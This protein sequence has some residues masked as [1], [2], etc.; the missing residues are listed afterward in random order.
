MYVFV[1][2]CMYVYL[3][4]YVLFLL[5]LAII[6]LLYYSIINMTLN[7]VS[8][9]QRKLNLIMKIFLLWITQNSTFILEFVEILIRS[10]YL[11]TS[12]T[13]Y[14]CCYSQL[15]IVWYNCEAPKKKKIT[16]LSPH[17]IS[18]YILYGMCSFTEPYLFKMI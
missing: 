11:Q 15:E 12:L 16:S 5:N 10:C 9:S 2:L 1:C 14:K 7:F 18:R 8:W 13:I 17:D 6:L 3:C 4:V